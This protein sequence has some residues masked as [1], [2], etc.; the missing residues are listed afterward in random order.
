MPFAR[1][2]RCYAVTAAVFLALDAVWLAIIA[3]A[4]REALGPLMR[5]EPLWPVA[6]GFYLLFVLGLLVFAV[7]PASATRYAALRAALFGA[8]TYATLEL[9]NLALIAGWPAWL[10]AA[11]I[12]WGGFVATAAAS[13]GHRFR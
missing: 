10:A 5:S 4:Y 3:P 6:I 1:Y 2:L 8:I 12:A 11:D 13:S 9:T 7:Y